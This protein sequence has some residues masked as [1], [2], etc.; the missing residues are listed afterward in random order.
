MNTTN[1]FEV[2]SPWADVDPLPLKGLTAPRLTDLKG[3]RIGIFKNFKAAADQMF[4]VLGPK[5]EEKFGCQT[6]TF[7]NPNMGV[8]EL[9]SDPERIKRFEEWLSNLDAVL[10]SHG[11]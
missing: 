11:D 4:A 3:K 6:S 1:Q 2:L 7:L 10:L 8:A 5:L 9:E